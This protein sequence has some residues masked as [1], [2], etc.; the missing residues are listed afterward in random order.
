MNAVENSWTLGNVRLSSLK[1]TFTINHAISVMMR[2]YV[3]LV[4]SSFSQQIIHV[5]IIETKLGFASIIC[6]SVQNLTMASLPFADCN[7]RTV[8]H[9]IFYSS[10]LFKSKCRASFSNTV[11]FKFVNAPKGRQEEMSILNLEL[12]KHQVRPR[13]DSIF[14]VHQLESTQIKKES[15]KSVTSEHENEDL[16]VSMRNFIRFGRIIGVIPLNGVWGKES[17]GLHFR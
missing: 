8:K 12:F 16:F 14:L 3:L 17:T 9:S 4:K 7:Q 2:L 13:E 1:S 15:L 11:Q 10:L 6:Y 5:R